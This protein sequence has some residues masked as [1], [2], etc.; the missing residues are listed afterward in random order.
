MSARRRKRENST[1][2]SPA[3][4]K[5]AQ[6]TVSTRTR[7]ALSRRRK[8]LFRLTA[9]IVAPLLFLAVLE[10]GLQL[11][12]YGYRAGFFIGPD[13]DGAYTPNPCFGWRFFPRAIARKAEPCFVSAKAPGTIRIFVLGSSAA[14]GVPNPSFGFSRLLEVMLRQ[15]YPEVK[16]E[17][18]NVAMTAINSHVGL[19][20]ARDCAAH[21]PDLFIVYMG[22]NEVVGP[23]GPGTVFQQWSPS[24]KLIRAN[25]WLKSTRTGQLLGDAMGRLRSGN[26]PPAAWQGME[27][28]LG[29]KVAADDPRLPAVY[30][31]YRQN[32]RDICEVARRAGAGVILSTMAVN[33]EDCPPL[34][35]Q[36]RSDLSAEE[37]AR[38]E[39]P[40]QAGVDL[41]GKKKQLEAIAKYESAAQIDDRYAE[42]QYRL[43][44]CLAAQQRS[45]QAGER[46]VLARD[47]DTLR[48]R[49]DSRIN[50]IVREVASE[51]TSGVRLVDA[52]KA[53][54]KGDL[55]PAGV[56]EKDLFY[57]HVHLTFDGNYTLARCMLDP[58]C[59]ALP[60]LAGARATETAISREKCADLL[61]LTPWDEYQMA[62]LM[63]EVMTRPP[64]KNQLDNAVHVALWR[65][66]AASLQKL[67]ATPQSLAT[68]FDRYEAAVEKSPEDW[69]LR[70]RFAQVAMATGHLGVAAEHLKAVLK[71]LPGDPAVCIEL[72]NVAMGSRRIDE[73]IGWF[74]K[75]LEIDPGLAKA[76]FDLAL[77]LS[78]R[79]K[80]DEA[81]DH[82]QQTL[83]IDSGC[84]QAHICIGLLLSNSGRIDE[85]V[86]QF[87]E[88]LKLDP[89]NT[90]AH[91]NLEK[92]L[93]TRS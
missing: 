89:S 53:F 28:F 32:L 70:R 43:G 81:I 52:E 84:V 7:P 12:G 54:A 67:A 15:R 37:L 65:E 44:R 58:V 85:A 49:A 21:Q 18:V 63:T 80:A 38:W 82:F 23:F 10:A 86:A 41:E 9:M 34:A 48:F 90:S 91:E 1:A 69:S 71:K 62:G 55:A 51:G 19:E 73:A 47:L 33:L 8:W 76:H 61:V 4:A 79:G 3:A 68:A 57:E 78:A 75:A 25:V 83:K 13:A 14:Q 66:R 36:H 40:Y 22:N 27:M 11:G 87:Q 35:S 2:A 16:F 42:L 31:N 5:A 45:A 30:D 29:N 39:S 74:H 20:I 93:K 60:E 26:A 72:G 59:K 56:A 24:R 6:A 46:F 92:L 64:F 77:A 88:V 50:A 17:V